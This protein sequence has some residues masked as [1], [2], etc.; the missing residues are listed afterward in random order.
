MKKQLL[1]IIAVLFF[2]GGFQQTK[3]QGAALNFVGGEY[4][5]VGN[6]ITGVLTN[7]NTIT[8]EAWVN[9]ST[10]S[11]LGV[12]A[13]NYNTG[14]GGM[15]FLL[16]RDGSNY[17][18]WVSNGSG[19]Q[20]VYSVSTV[21]ANI[22]Q[23][24]AGTWD[25]N[26][27]NIYINGVLDNTTT[28]VTGTLVTE[29]NDVWIGND[30]L[31]EQFTGSIDEV[32]IW[33]I[34]RTQT[35]IQNN[36]NCAVASNAT[37]LVLYYN[38]D[39][40]TPNVT[41]TVTTV[42]DLTA[43]ANAGTLVN[44]ALT[45]TSSN[46]VPNATLSVQ[47]NTTVTAKLMTLC[48]GVADTL[49]ASGTT[50]GTAPYVYTWHPAGAVSVTGDTNIVTPNSASTTGLKNWRVVTVD[51]NG[52]AASDTVKVQV[53]ALPSVS[54]AAKI[55]TPLCAGITDTLIANVTGGSGT[56]TTYSWTPGTHVNSDT[57]LFKS[58]TAGTKNWKVIVTDNNNCSSAQATF[59]VGVVANPTV[60]L[61]AKIPTTLCAGIA[62]TL[63]VNV[64]GGSGV[65]TT[66]SWSPSKPNKDTAVFT[67]SNPGSKKWSVM[68]ADDNNCYSAWDTV[69]LSVVANP[70]VSLSAKI[71]GTLCAGVADTLIANVTGGSGVIT[72]YSWS[73]S[74]PNKDTAVFTS[75]NPGSKKW[76]VMVADNNNCYSAWDTVKITVVVPTTATISPI[77]CNSVTVNATT[78]TAS[79]IYTQNLTNAAGC[80]S[81]LT[82]MA[83]VNVPT[84]ATINP[85]GC[86]SVVVNVIT[87]T[88]SGT[89]TQSL[90]NVAG[91]DS[92][93]TI[94]ATVNSSPT[95]S[96]M[97]KINGPICQRSQNIKDTLIA[98]VSGGS[99]TYTTYS[100]TP[101]IHLNSDT[102]VFQA[103]SLPGV[104]NWKLVVTDNNGCSSTQ[105]TFS[106]TIVSNPLV[107]VDSAAICPNNTATLTASS[108]TAISY[109]WNTGDIGVSI[110]PSPTA[111]TN[112]TVTGTD[113]NGCTGKAIS[114]VTIL[115][116]TTATITLSGC[117]A[118]VVNATTYTASGTFTQTLTNAAGCDSILTINATVNS[119][120]VISSQ[121]G[122]VK[123]C[124]STSGSFTVNSPGTNNYKWY[125]ISVNN[126]NDTIADI[127]NY[128]EV[129]F[130][131]NSMTITNINNEN[132]VLNGP[133]AVECLITNSTTGCSVLSQP[134]T[135]NVVPNPVVTIS[136]ST[137]TLCAG[138]SAT[139]TANGANTYTWSNTGD[140]TSSISPVVNS[141]TQFTLT[142][143]DNNGCVGM[144]T[145]TI[146]TQDC[147]TGINKVA[148]SSEEI[149]VYP[150]PSNGNFVIAT[151]ADAKAII[152]TDMLGNE[153][154]SISPNG[155]TTNVNLSAQP[156]G[157]YFVKVITNG[158][159][160]V[161]HIT[162]TN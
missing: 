6:S 81:I 104:K 35:A 55:A 30:N 49:I 162:I 144:D 77:G 100:W 151:A 18:F 149:A 143:V 87:Y 96:I 117:N 63:I 17:T 92:I 109:T 20:N 160:V 15:Q 107:N 11:G 122:S 116:P 145:L 101:G 67:S 44:F 66:Y 137:T 71:N 40:G 79:G 82:I 119:A 12:I 110:T 157:I 10:A 56:Y 111:T 33:N 4:I 135:I 21:T 89:Y 120:P 62:D 37:G 86:D 25:G 24:V 72:T 90:T 150:N 88:A 51:N 31:G 38:F 64:T 126:P 115:N 53:N 7:L 26:N 108:S 65:I 70:T 23:H 85:V 48:A 139:L 146:E 121:S 78:Y 158:K 161:K 57:A 46:F 141:T 147:T 29:A 2:I 1:L 69:K 60:T 27:L 130:T 125:W 76:S 5:D 91:C 133:Y 97:A 13:G 102:A 61:T 93:L 131:T 140:V 105:Q 124:D 9:P 84:T 47:V 75:S 155:T 58:S 28:G 113:N 74:K 138:L 134:D 34:A 95:A 94:N 42:P 54:I 50:G 22:W 41:N 153:L 8:V 127:G 3:A 154:M 39:N 159:Q 129:N 142:G 16:R 68:V 36:M 45:G 103:G 123:V 59:S 114:L 156:S 136:A 98:S 148:S 132:W 152:V 14:D 52:C 43:N 112:Y 106:L 128:Q 19:F 32:K 73:P 83:T 118:I 80:D 99:G